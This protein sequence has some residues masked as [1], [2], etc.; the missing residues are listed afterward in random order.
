MDSI[1]TYVDVRSTFAE[2]SGCALELTVIEEVPGFRK[3]L[4]AADFVPHSEA[5]Q[6]NSRGAVQ[7]GAVELAVAFVLLPGIHEK[8]AD[9][10]EQK[11]Q[12]Y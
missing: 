4:L 2:I 1:G 9:K 3:F 6:D 7:Q 5:P 12:Q 8:P 11:R 10:Q